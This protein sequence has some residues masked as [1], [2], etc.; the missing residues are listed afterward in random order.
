MSDIKPKK[1]LVTLASDASGLVSKKVLINLDT[2]DRDVLSYDQRGS[3]LLFDIENF[4]KLDASVIEKLS[5][6]NRIR[7]ETC[8][9]LY[10]DLHSQDPDVE[11]TQRFID[12]S[13]SEGLGAAEERLAILNKNDDEYFYRWSRTDKV[14][15]RLQRGYVYVRDKD[16]ETLNNKPGEIQK[17]GRRGEEELILM[18]LPRK[19]YNEREAKKEALRKE[20]SEGAVRRGQEQIASYGVP[21]ATDADLFGTGRKFEDL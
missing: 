9:E 10:N 3:C 4:K 15:S 5:R 19:L 8:L 17:I 2:S 14:R 20:R 13:A 6:E 1:P 11:Q 7:Y 12:F 18:K 21:P 16:L